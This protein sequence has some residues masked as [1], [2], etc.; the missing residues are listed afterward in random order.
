MCVPVRTSNAP[1]SRNSER[2][3]SFLQ[4]LRAPKFTCAQLLDND[5]DIVN[6]W[7]NKQPQAAARSARWPRQWTIAARWP[8]AGRRPR[9]HS[10][11]AREAGFWKPPPG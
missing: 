4:E 5:Q 8:K 3:M 9:T 1:G 2:D 6:A 7:K 11:A 10:S